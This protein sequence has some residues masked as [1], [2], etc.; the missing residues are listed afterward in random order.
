MNNLHAFYDELQHVRWVLR[1]LVDS[2][3]PPSAI[4]DGIREHRLYPSL[5]AA[6]TTD[7]H[8][9]AYVTDRQE[10]PRDPDQPQP[11]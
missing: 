8:L 6:G 4:A 3:A 7:T 10:A 2:G 11:G 1:D 9:V 5:T